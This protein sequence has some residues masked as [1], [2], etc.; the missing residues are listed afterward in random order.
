MPDQV[1]AES[2]AIAHEVTK[3]TGRICSRLLLR[4]LQ[5]LD[6]Q[7]NA[8]TQVLVQDVVV[9]TCVADSEARKLARISIL[10]TAALNSG[11]NKPVFEQFLVEELRVPA[12]VADEVAYFGADA[13]I[14][15]LD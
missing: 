14:G 15:V 8:R 10:V 4:V 13:G 6:Q 11:L 9:E 2:V 5:Q 7:H 12:E 1:L 3:R